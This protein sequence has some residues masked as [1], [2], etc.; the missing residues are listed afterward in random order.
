MDGKWGLIRA[1]E[2]NAITW[3]GEEDYEFGWN[4]GKIGSSKAAWATKGD[5]DL[6]I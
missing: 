1:G 3:V 5:L 4:L 2:H 6:K